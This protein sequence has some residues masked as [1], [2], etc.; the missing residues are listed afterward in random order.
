MYVQSTY[1]GILDMYITWSTMSSCS[2][3]SQEIHSLGSKQASWG[4]CCTMRLSLHTIT[5]RSLSYPGL[6]RVLGLGRLVPRYIHMYYV[7]TIYVCIICMY[8]CV[9]SSR[10]IMQLGTDKANVAR[11]CVAGARGTVSNVVARPYRGSTE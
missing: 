7:C 10:K 4:Y 9:Y 1:I 6:P 11:V 3:L 2:R 5:L 8:G